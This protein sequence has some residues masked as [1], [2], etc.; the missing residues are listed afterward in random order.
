MFSIKYYILLPEQLPEFLISLAD[1]EIVIN[2]ELE[3]NKLRIQT[4]C[5]EQE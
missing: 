4:E 5:K 2:C 3:N 1:N